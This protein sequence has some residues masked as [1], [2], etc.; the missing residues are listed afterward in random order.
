MLCDD[1]K[2]DS[3]KV[4]LDKVRKLTANIIPLEKGEESGICG[5]KVDDSLDCIVLVGCWVKIE[6]VTRPP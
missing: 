2:P 5:L 3:L 6:E 4:V 1:P